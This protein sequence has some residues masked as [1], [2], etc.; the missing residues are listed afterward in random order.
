MSNHL[1]STYKYFK[2]TI[3]VVNGEALNCSKNSYAK[4]IVFSKKSTIAKHLVINRFV[5]AL[6][7]FSFVDFLRIT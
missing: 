1:N 2:N 7:L 3:E 4:H 5:F 6:L